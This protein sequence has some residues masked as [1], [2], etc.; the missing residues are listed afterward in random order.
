MDVQ[1]RHHTSSPKAACAAANSAYPVGACAGPQ[2]NAN[3]STASLVGKS[4]FM[5]A[6]LAGVWGPTTSGDL[7]GFVGSPGACSFPLQL[8]PEDFEVDPGVTDRQ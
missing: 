6:P 5:T 4:F 7:P 2:A 8:A 3:A 1:T